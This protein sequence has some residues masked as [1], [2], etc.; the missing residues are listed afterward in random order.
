MKGFPLYSLYL[1]FE[2]CVGLSLSQL[3]DKPDQT[4]STFGVC[5]DAV[6][7]VFLRKTVQRSYK[8]QQT[9]TFANR[10]HRSLRKFVILF[11]A[12]FTAALGHG[13]VTGRMCLMDVL[14]KKG[15]EKKR[16]KVN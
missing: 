12:A 15:E 5:Q 14:T 9:N 8:N 11:W 7:R 3:C 2:D 13:W 4:R 10:Y 1:F 16:Q 6:I